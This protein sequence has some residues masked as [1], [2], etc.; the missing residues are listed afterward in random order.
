MYENQQVNRSGGLLPKQPILLS[1]PDKQIVPPPA[2]VRAG[3]EPL[4][5]IARAN[6]GRASRRF[7]EFFVATRSRS[8]CYPP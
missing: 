5:V 6:G 8:G 1:E 7:I 3:F 2:L 4:R